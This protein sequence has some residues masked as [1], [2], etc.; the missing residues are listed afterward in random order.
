MFTVGIITNPA[1]GKDIRRLVSQ[2]RVISNQEKI[3]IVRRILAGLEASGVEKILLMPDYSNLSI[4]A[5]REYGGNMQI[6]SL[7]MPV[8]NNDQDTTRAAEKMA[9][10]GAVSY[11]H[12]TL[13]TICSV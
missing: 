2:S 9:L 4:T 12:L 1:S 7:D 8:F 13:P 6:E 11:T 5:A 3:N 10:S